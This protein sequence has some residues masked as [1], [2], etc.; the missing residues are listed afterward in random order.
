MD[1]LSD[2]FAKA[3]QD[4]LAE[5]GTNAFAFE[6]RAGLPVD[7][8]RS[9]IRD[10]DKRAIPRINRAKQICDA[11]GL[12]FYIGPPRDLSPGNETLKAEEFTKVPLLDAHLAAGDGHSNHVE[13]LIGHLAF[14]KDWL[15]RLGVTAANAVLARAKGDSMQPTI[16]DNDMVLVDTARKS[17]SVRSTAAARRRTPIY[18]VLDQGEARLKRIERPTEEQVLLLSDNPDYAP[19]ICHPRDLSII[20]KVLWWGHTSQE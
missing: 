18:A 15:S 3:V 16:W 11:L 8:V 2:A 14:R 17:V 10:D 7:A 19:E 20:G 6:K 12:E 1:D 9:V 5:L 4:Q 13:L